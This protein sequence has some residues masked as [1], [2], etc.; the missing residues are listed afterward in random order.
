M[1]SKELEKILKVLASR[2]RLDI[3][4]FLK[5]KR[6]VTVGDIAQEIGL[7]FKSTSK[8]L[9]ILYSADILER[10]NNS[11]EGY[12]RLA[13]IDNEVI[14]RIVKSITYNW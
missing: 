5:N 2:R 8:H 13:E 1:N 10:D 14:K 11:L 12:Y 6:G 7:S 3:I 9:R 4:R